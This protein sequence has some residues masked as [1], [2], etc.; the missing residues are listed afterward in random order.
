MMSSGQQRTSK[1]FRDFAGD[2]RPLEGDK[3]KIEEILGREIEITGY[4]VTQSKFNR[5]NS[6]RC[7]MVQFINEHGQK[8]VFFTGSAVLINQLEKY[9]SEIPFV[10]TVQK[11]QRYFTLT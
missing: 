11:I 2:D 4:R 3:V 10:A 9:G 1:R 7:L 8:Q 6:P 5:S